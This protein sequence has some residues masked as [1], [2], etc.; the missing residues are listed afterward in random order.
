[1]RKLEHILDL[2]ENLHVLYVEDNL[3]LLEST[4]ELFK[5]YFKEVDTAENGKEGL[6]KYLAFKEKNGNFYD[7]VITDINMPFLDGIELSSKI[8]DKNFTQAIIIT[9]A[10]NEVEYLSKAINLGIDGFIIKP[11]KQ[12]ELMKVIYKSAQAINDHKM[13]DAYITMMEELTIKV[14]EQN[15]ELN[16]RNSELEK[17]TRILDTIIHKD[18]IISFMKKIEQNIDT[19]DYDKQIQE[20]INN[21]LYE[22]KELLTEIDVN[23]IEIINDSYHISSERLVLLAKLF[24]KYAS[25]LWFYSFFAELASAMT[26]FSSTINNNPLPNN[27]QSV[28]NIFVLLESFVYVIGKWQEDLESGD[29]S[30]VNILDASLN[31]DMKTITHMWLEEEVDVQNIFDF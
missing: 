13:V 27:E 22:L 28:K 8:L 1:M 20:L 2:T 31:S 5:N 11:I 25:V 16:D 6:E 24:S 10:H 14:E 9:T 29:E 18:T 12:D 21:P 30:K 26:N 4:R 23:L 3:L 7:I 19:E 15:I 17:S